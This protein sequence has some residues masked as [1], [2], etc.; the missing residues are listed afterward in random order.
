MPRYYE[1]YCPVKILCGE[2]ALEN[3]PYELKQRNALRPLVLT[4]K[5]VVN[6]G[7]LKP[8]ADSFSGSNVKIA[9][10][11]DDI[12]PD[13][14][15]DILNTV[16][17]LFKKEKC[18]SL[19][20]VG[21]GSVI[22]TA[23]GANIL[24][25]EGVSDISERAGVDRLT[26]EMLPLIVVPTT[27]GTGS[28]VTCAAVIADKT[29]GVKLLFASERL[30]PDVAVLDA[31]MTMTLPQYI[32]A[33]TGMDALTHAIEAYT[34]LQKNPMSDAY[35]YSAIRLIT[36]NLV[37]AVKDGKNIQRRLALTQ[38]SCMAGIAFSNSLVGMVHA[39]GHSL[40]AVCH[41]PHG[42]AMSIFLP[43]GMEYNIEKISEYLSELLLPLA[44]AEIYALTPVEK[45]AD[46]SI[47]RVRALRDQLFILAKLP[48][49]LSEAG[50]KK[51]SFREIAEK[52]MGDGSV[53]INPVE[54]DY[55]DAL[56]ILEKAF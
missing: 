41:I 29:R 2:Q 24:I 34:C 55:N 28:E 37:E 21:G 4:D 13:S 48:R 42:V 36:E 7:L 35:A 45:R 25:S 26:A 50:V 56:N 23:K 47:L 8:L 52:A 49:T 44:G 17:V 30:M 22:D 38:A 5:G 33:A 3:I 15:I 53:I 6:A 18:D 11:F 46:E 43:F 9:A 16:A 10:V 31:R 12:P 27:S 54:I 32:T 14:S 20:A 39:L 51:D 1:F 19:I 40:G